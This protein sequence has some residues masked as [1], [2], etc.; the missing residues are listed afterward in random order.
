MR[1]CI[2]DFPGASAGTARADLPIEE[3][4]AVIRHLRDCPS[5]CADWRIATEGSGRRE[6]TASN[7]VGLA[8]A[9]VIA[10]AMVLGIWQQPGELPAP[11]FRIGGEITIE[12]LAGEGGDYPA[13]TSSCAGVRSV[14]TLA[15]CSK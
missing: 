10:A 8:A 6:T 9:A 1:S 7:W 12:S 3:R 5:C 15:T 2:A 14:K 13:A 11:S 4:R